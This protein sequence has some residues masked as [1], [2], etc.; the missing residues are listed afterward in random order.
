MSFVFFFFNDT[1]TTE[2]YTLS[3]H[4]ALPRPRRAAREPQQGQPP[5]PLPPDRPAQH[6][7]GHGRRPAEPRHPATR[8]PAPPQPVR[9][10]RATVPADRPA[11]R[12]LRHRH[13][14]IRRPLHSRRTG[15]GLVG[16]PD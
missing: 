2:I 13:I 10:L 4:D 7:A 3:L 1:A 14:H 9:T 11:P 6:R 12:P 16:I 5:A 15:A 8:R